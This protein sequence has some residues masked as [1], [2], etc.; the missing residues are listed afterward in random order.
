MPTTVADLVLMP[1]PQRAPDTERSR[2]RSDKIML[3][4]LHEAHKN[5]V[6]DFAVFP[7]ALADPMPLG[8]LRRHDVYVQS[9]P[10]MLL[11][12]KPLGSLGP[13]VVAYANPVP[14]V[15]VDATER[16]SPELAADDASVVPN[17]SYVAAWVYSETPP[18]EINALVPLST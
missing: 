16:P 15:A 3:A 18:P 6:A 17:L 7:G 14:D 13:T 2:P 10:D 9:V 8:S 1:D 5:L 12:P 4:S 11:D